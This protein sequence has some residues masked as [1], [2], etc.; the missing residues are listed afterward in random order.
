MD[1]CL[2]PAVGSN[3][4]DASAERGAMGALR[5]FALFGCSAAAAEN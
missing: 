2:D 3:L 1:F 4:L 5:S